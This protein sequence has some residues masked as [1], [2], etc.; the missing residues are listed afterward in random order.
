MALTKKDWQD[1]RPVSLKGHGVGKAMEA[2][3]KINTRTV[4]GA[5]KGLAA[6]AELSDLLETA[7][8]KDNTLPA[9]FKAAVVSWKNALKRLLVEVQ[10]DLKS[11][12]RAEANSEGDLEANRLVRE[13]LSI[14]SDVRDIEK[15]LP[16]KKTDPVAPAVL[17]KA[18]ADYAKLDKAHDLVTKKIAGKD[19]EAGMRKYLAKHFSGYIAKGYIAVGDLP[20]PGYRDSLEAQAKEMKKE[21]EALGEDLKTRR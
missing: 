10:A 7:P 2:V 11:G 3:S 18:K 13:V 15:V 20:D 1:V 4:D 9:D 5:I 12:I 16:K 8:I 19:T 14:R 17:T 6:I 21:V